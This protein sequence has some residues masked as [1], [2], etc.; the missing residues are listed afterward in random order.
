RNWARDC[1]RARAR[2]AEKE[3]LWSDLWD[4]AT[5]TAP[6]WVARELSHE[7]RVLR[8]EL[9]EVMVQTVE[10]FPPQRELFGAHFLREESV[11][12]IAVRSGQPANTVHQS[13]WQLRRKLR[14]VLERHGWGRR[15]LEEYLAGDPSD[16]GSAPSPEPQKNHP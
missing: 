9:V 14:R 16:G 3:V 1:V 7:A 6:E 4:E 11:M 10:E 13:L 8:A 12:E 5:A 15:E 2:Q